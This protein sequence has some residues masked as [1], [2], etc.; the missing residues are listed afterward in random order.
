MKAQFLHAKE[1]LT[2][3]I[4][5]HNLDTEHSSK[6]HRS[7]D[8]KKRQ[9]KAKYYLPEFLRENLKTI[10]HERSTILNIVDSSSEDKDLPHK[11]YSST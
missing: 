7:I 5:T 9:E 1:N 10:I 2:H 3:K 6:A 11:R 8:L 4:F